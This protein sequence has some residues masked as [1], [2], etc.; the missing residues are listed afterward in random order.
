MKRRNLIL[1]LGGASSGAMSVGTGAFSSMEA[2]R[3]VEV[4]VADDENA[5]IRYETP[6]DGASVEYGQQVTLVRVR[7]QFGGNQ[8]LA[9]VA[10]STS[11]KTT[12][13]RVTYCETSP[14]S[15][16]IAKR[17]PT[18]RSA[19]RTSPTSTRIT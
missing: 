12:T 9:L 16:T 14:S 15:A 1:L 18:K 19:T 7:N 10:S 13:E 11:T 5:Y 8:D 2:E 17:L 4:N 3:G 6:S